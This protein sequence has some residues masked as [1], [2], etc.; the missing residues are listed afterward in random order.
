MTCIL[1]HPVT[2]EIEVDDIDDQLAAGYTQIEI[3]RS[4]SG[5]TGAF[6]EVTSSTTRPALV[7]NQTHY[8]FED[9]D[10]SPAYWYKYQFRNDAGTLLSGFN[11]PFQV[12]DSALQICSI[13]DLKTFYLLGIDLT[14]DNGVPFPDSL[15]QHY[16]IEAVDHWEKELDIAIR[17]LVIEDEPGSEEQQDYFREDYN[18]YIWIELNYFPVVEVTSVQLV[19]PGEAVVQI[20]NREWIHI[21]RAAGQVQLVPG[22]GTAGTI[23]LGASGAWIPL[24]YGNNRY[25]PNVFRIAYRAGFGRPSPGATDPTAGLTGPKSVADPILD[26]GVPRDIKHLIG[27]RAALGPL[28]IAGDLIVGAGIA[29]QSIGIDGLS[30]SVSTTSSATNAGYGARIIQY[31]KDIKALEKSLKDYYKGIRMRIV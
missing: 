4:T 18:N 5:S 8:T 17:P 28:N 23:L 3:H 26:R 6:E 10:G 24:I 11:T 2:L 7:A 31:Q 27:M 20:F 29:S 25:I 9:V 30:Q 19:L 15:F 13:E 12:T 22:T 1:K 21:E 16:I 14:D